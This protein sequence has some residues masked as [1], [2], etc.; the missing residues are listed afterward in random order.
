M[1]FYTSPAARTAWVAEAQKR[2]KER[3]GTP[4]HAMQD[5]GQSYLV[6]VHGHG[7]GGVPRAQLGN[8]QHPQPVDAGTLTTPRASALGSSIGSNP[9]TATLASL[10]Y[11]DGASPVIT[12]PSA[13]L[14]QP[15]PH[16]ARPTGGTR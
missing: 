4:L 15:A 1:P 2:E 16:P 6:D 11:R 10:N 7:H 13:G 5:G 3:G 14:A 9:G 8:P 12:F